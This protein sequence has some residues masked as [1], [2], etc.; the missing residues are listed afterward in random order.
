M[1]DVFL[2][3]LSPEAQKILALVQGENINIKREHITAK[4]LIDIENAIN[5]HLNWVKTIDLKMPR[6]KRDF[7]LHKI[8][9]LLMMSSVYN[10]LAPDNPTANKVQNFASTIP[11]PLLKKLS[12]VEK[13]QTPPPI[14]KRKYH[15][16]L[17]YGAE[18][19]RGRLDISACL[20][21]IN[22]C[23]IYSQKNY[24]QNHPTPYIA[25]INFYFGMVS[26]I[27]PF[28]N[29]GILA[30]QFWKKYCNDLA[31]DFKT[32]QFDLLWQQKRLSFLKNFLNLTLN[33]TTFLIGILELFPMHF[34][35]ASI[36][37]GLDF[38][39]YC[40]DYH[41]K[42]YNYIIQRQQEFTN[43][44]QKLPDDYNLIYFE[45]YL[46][47]KPDDRIEY[48]CEIYEKTLADSALAD[49]EACLFLI[50]SMISNEQKNKTI[51]NKFYLEFITFSLMLITLLVIQH[52]VFP[53]LDP[54]LTMMMGLLMLYI[55]HGLKSIIIENPIQVNQHFIEL[56]DSEGKSIY[57]KGGEIS[58]DS[59]FGRCASFDLQLILNVG[60]KIALPVIGM[61]MLLNMAPTLA[62]PLFVSL[63]ICIKLAE[64]S[65]KKPPNPDLEPIPAK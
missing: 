23:F 24:T 10:T 45:K 2:K 22:A 47:L 36:N 53:S 51:T 30:N 48:L 46:T 52:T 57:L 59:S 35:F 56:Q 28:V 64:I 39:F 38:A 44:E 14:K 19:N 3:S 18:L 41:E 11:L 58:Q 34:Y 1:D 40:W 25:D 33:I 20:G 21:L 13:T 15:Q 7:I 60:V 8:Q 42:N 65:L 43:L 50:L 61:I 26:L 6:D 54:E 32:K 49:K 12:L 4:G 17:F 55:Y 29:L 63:S 31:S 5:F 16:M 37:V 62:I 9:T 27:L